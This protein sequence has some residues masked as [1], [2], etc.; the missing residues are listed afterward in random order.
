MFGAYLRQN[1]RFSFRPDGHRDVTSMLLP[2]IASLRR[3]QAGDSSS[4][5]IQT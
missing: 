3:W 5:C 4:I 2:A 1:L